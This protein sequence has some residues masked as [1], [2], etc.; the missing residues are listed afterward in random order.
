[1]LTPRQFVST[2]IWNQPHIKEL[3]WILQW[4]LVK[5][6]NLVSISPQQGSLCITHAALHPAYGFT[7]AQL[8]EYPAR[9]ESAKIGGLFFNRTKP[10]I[11][12]PEVDDPVA[13]ARLFER[14]L[15]DVGGKEVAEDVPGAAPGLE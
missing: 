6:I 15:Q 9:G 8:T 4:L 2:N 13:T 1:M 3:P 12:R 10:G 11:T 14:A 5:V 7:P